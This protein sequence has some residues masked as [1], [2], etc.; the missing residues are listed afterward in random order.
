MQCKLGKGR[1]RVPVAALILLAPLVIFGL[2]GSLIAPH[3]I[4]GPP[5]S[6]NALR[7][8]AWMDGGSWS[9]LLGTDKLGRDLLSV[10]MVGARTSLIVCVV[11]VLFAGIIGIIL[12]LL[13]GYFGKWVD[14]LIM[15]VVDIVMSIPGILFMLL[16]AAA[17][18]PGIKTIIISMGLLMWCGY[19]RV[20]RGEVL[21]VKEREFVSMAKVMGVSRPRILA[22]HILP[23]VGS[24][25]IVMASLQ[26]GGAIMMEGG[27]SF[28]GLGVQPPYTTWGRIIAENRN[29]MTTAWWVPV[30]AGL[31]LIMA[32]WGFNVLG[33]W[34][35]DVLDP[36]M[37]RR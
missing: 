5:D 16:F 15:R 4:M 26:A 11:G 8:P 2:F 9:Y 21:S 1:R 10:L 37:R 29:V 32:I 3:E 12:G 28:L 23:S 30:F 20:M 6:A 31:L 35:R 33:D 27:L 34:L 24:T 18:G 25:V 19:T 7:P 22:R 36:K 14:N 13:A 17:L